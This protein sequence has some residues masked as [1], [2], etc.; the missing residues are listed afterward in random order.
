MSRFRSL[1][2]LVILALFGCL[3]FYRV[4]QMETRS[5]PAA[6]VNSLNLITHNGAVTTTAT[7]DT[8][9]V[10]EIARYAY[11]RDK[12]D[13]EKKVQEITIQ[14]T[15]ESNTWS[16]SAILPKRKQHLGALF[17]ANCPAN[18]HLNI[19]TSNGKVTVSGLKNGVSVFTSNGQVILIGTEGD[20]QIN[21]T[22]GKVTVQVHSGGI[23]IQT[24]NGEIDCDLVLLPATKSALLSTT[25]GKVTLRLPPDVSAT[26]EATTT[27]GTVVVTGYRVEY[28]QQSQ[29]HIRARIGSGASPI[30]ITTSNGDIVIQSRS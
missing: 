3:Y 22:N 25:N 11:G 30:S 7:E 19:H 13:A 17:D 21:T 28:E 24:S 26:I 9:L 16:L 29:K 14:D 20:A 6:L 4:E 15:I 10:V 5:R 1:F 23:A 2:F 12:S 18:T 27:N 8:N